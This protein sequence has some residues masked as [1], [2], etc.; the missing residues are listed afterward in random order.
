MIKKIIIGIFLAGMIGVLIWGGVNRTLAR[1][2]NHSNNNQ[3]NKSQGAGSRSGETGGGRWGQS[4]SQPQAV[5]NYNTSLNRNGSIEECDSDCLNSSE[6]NETNQYRGNSRQNNSQQQANPENG[7]QW[8][9]RNNITNMGG[10]GRGGRNNGNG[11]YQTPLTDAEIQALQFAL[12]NEYKA[13]ATY[14]SVIDTFGDVEPFSLIMLSEQ[15]HISALVNQFTKHNV[16]VPPNP[17]LGEIP[18]FESLSEACVAGVETEKANVL[19]YEDL[20]NQI[21]NESLMRVFSNL[22]RASLES[23]LPEFEACQ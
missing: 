17:W 12:D 11:N 5:I 22:S 16:P 1:S 7:T 6:Y 18:I 8:T 4:S 20:F 13:F 14:S 15:R 23:H 9:G 10:N 19:L 3:Q 21:Q 2:D